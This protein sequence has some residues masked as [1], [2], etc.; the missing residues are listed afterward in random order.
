MRGVTSENMADGFISA[1][2][3]PGGRKQNRT[4]DP[5]ASDEERHRDTVCKIMEEVTINRELKN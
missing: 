1:S 4:G 3:N 5:L 2:L